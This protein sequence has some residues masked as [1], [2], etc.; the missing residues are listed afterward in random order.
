MSIGALVALRKLL[1][2]TVTISTPEPVAALSD[3]E[4]VGV[5]AEG[6]VVRPSGLNDVADAIA[7]G[8]I[9]E[10]A[11][12]IPFKPRRGAARTRGA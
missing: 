3:S 8:G 4:R 11:R 2:A 5:P 1:P 7:G 12:V 9:E 6:D 10:A